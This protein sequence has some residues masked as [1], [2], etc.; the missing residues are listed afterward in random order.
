MQT[1]TGPRRIEQIQAG[2]RVLAACGRGVTTSFLAQASG[3][4][5]VGVDPDEK[6]VEFDLQPLRAR[7]RKEAIEHGA[8]LGPDRPQQL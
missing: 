8:V 3:A 4:G 6:L 1:P 7:T 5:C 2:D